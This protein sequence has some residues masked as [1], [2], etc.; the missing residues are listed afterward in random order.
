MLKRHQRR[1]A[2]WARAHDIIVPNPLRHRD[3]FAIKVSMDPS[4]PSARSRNMLP[5]SHSPA[6]VYS[7]I[8]E[9]SSIP[10]ITPD[11]MDIT[12]CDVD[13]GDF[14]NRLS[15]AYERANELLRDIRMAQ[16][17]PTEDI[18]A[19]LPQ[20][21][22]NLTESAFHILKAMRDAINTNSEV[23]LRDFIGNERSLNILLEIYSPLRASVL[24][25]KTETKTNQDPE[26]KH[27]ALERNGT[28]GSNSPPKTHVSTD[29]APPREFERFGDQ[30]D[31]VEKESYE[32]DN[33]AIR[34]QQHSA[35]LMKDWSTSDPLI[36][37]FES[38]VNTTS[39]IVR[40]KSNFLRPDNYIGIKILNNA[41]P[42]KMAD[43]TVQMK[44]VPTLSECFQ[45]PRGRQTTV[46]SPWLVYVGF[47]YPD[48]THIP[49][50]PIEDVRILYRPGDPY[51][52][53]AKMEIST[54]VYR[55]IQETARVGFMK[56][57][58]NSE[59]LLPC[60]T[61]I[62]TTLSLV[63]IFVRDDRKVRLIDPDETR[64]TTVISALQQ[65]CHGIFG[66]CHM[67]LRFNSVDG[68]Q[69]KFRLRFFVFNFIV[70]KDAHNW[71][72]QV[73]QIVL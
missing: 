71:K 15:A 27:Q 62:N 69:R 51:G 28:R 22:Q 21:I 56:E 67:Q 60:S 42:K 25:A 23:G 64:C 33:Y 38:A 58:P 20:R 46:S 11:F 2:R 14:G 3:K 7:E 70:V 52:C 5:D 31:P 17:I 36:T 48:Q 16:Y 55:H 43:G 68:T 47:V 10:M 1:R 4:Y 66:E 54:Q 41:F 61:N 39:V 13:I 30:K 44:C 19:N 32:V 26:E 37:L 6:E 72:D 24:L 73:F 34:L 12:T 53:A 9:I 40:N 29:G 18:V 57:H 45:L 49:F 8:N 35:F 50:I 59:V 65:C 63:D